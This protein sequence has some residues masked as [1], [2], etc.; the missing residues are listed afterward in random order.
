MNIKK[1]RKNLH[2]INAI[3]GAEDVALNPIEKD[4]VKSYLLNMY[5]NLDQ[6]DQP[7]AKNK[8]KET[9]DERRTLYV[10]PT[11][12]IT[13]EV[14]EEK[15]IHQKN[16]PIV[17]PKSETI[18]ED[19]IESPVVEIVEEVVEEKQPS[20]EPEPIAQSVPDADNNTHT[21]TI[22]SALFDFKNGNDISDKLS[23]LPIADLTR[24]MGI[25]EYIFT[26]D[27]LFGGD[28]NRMVDS[29]ESMNK[30]SNFNL[31]K[32][33]LEALALDYNWDSPNKIKK[34]KNFIQLVRR[35]YH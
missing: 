26:K 17:E 33:E 14:E 29:L 3:I 20:P 12:V 34:A 8:S 21:R 22:D 1:F 28:Q 35:R 19:K 4:L 13:E 10:E 24:C 11:P 16:E 15:V 31:A 23:N 7:K 30:L 5:E 32:I 2:K 25:N 9:G 18:L 6:L 27:E